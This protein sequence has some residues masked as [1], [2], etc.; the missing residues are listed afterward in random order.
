MYSE[1]H[2]TEIRLA[3]VWKQTGRAGLT[4]SKGTS[5]R[6]RQSFQRRGCLSHQ[7]DGRADVMKQRGGLCP[8][9]PASPPPSLPSF[10]LSVNNV[11]EPWLCTGHSARPRHTRMGENKCSPAIMQFTPCS[12]VDVCKSIFKSMK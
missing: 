5:W 8:F 7:D 4:G 2:L 1:S 11:I 9:L 12:T 10:F 6:L 3:E